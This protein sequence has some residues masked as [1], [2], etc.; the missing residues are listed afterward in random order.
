MKSDSLKSHVKIYV[1]FLV[2]SEMI[3]TFALERIYLHIKVY[4]GF[5][6][7]RATTA[8]WETVIARISALN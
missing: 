7:Y 5:S 2:L 3:T 4:D 8:P 6:L 1:L